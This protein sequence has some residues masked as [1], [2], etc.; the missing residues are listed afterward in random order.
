MK[1]IAFAMAAV[2]ALFCFE[3]HAQ[4]MNVG[5][6]ASPSLPLGDF[7]DAAEFGIGGGLSFDYY[8]NDHFNLG[9]EGEYIVF[10]VEA[11]NVD[12]S[13]NLIPVQLTGAY[14]TDAENILDL[15][16]GTGV[17][18]FTMGS[19]VEGT[20]SN[21]NFGISPRVGLAWEISDLLFF[22]FNVRYS[23]IFSEDEKTGGTNS[24]YL[25]FN[26]GLLYSLVD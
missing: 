13:F 17:G 11:D 8:F 6:N 21:S 1:K 3:G 16:A 12:E 26:V 4:K 24:S 10:P 15:Y 14:H 20:E 9:V 19:S 25:G 7:G 5:I 2:A 22:D 18:I 23:M